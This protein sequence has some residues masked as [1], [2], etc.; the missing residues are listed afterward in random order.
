MRSTINPPIPQAGT[1]TPGQSAAIPPGQSR[2]ATSSTHFSP[3]AH[4]KPANVAH[5][6]FG[7][8]TPGQSCAAPQL[9]FGSCTHDSLDRQG[10]KPL[11][12]QSRFAGSAGFVFSTQM[13][14]QSLPFLVGSQVS[15]GSSTQISSCDAHWMLPK[16]PQK[17]GSGQ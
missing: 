12:S 8:Q 3:F 2:F 7:V 10:G 4:C 15:R 14:L 11:E 9:L 1:Q 17:T 16:P 13:P 5:N 6:F